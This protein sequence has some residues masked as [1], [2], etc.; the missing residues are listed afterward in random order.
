MSTKQPSGTTRDHI[1]PS[2]PPTASRRH[3]TGLM[4]TAAE[5]TRVKWL[6]WRTRQNRN[7]GQRQVANGHQ[8][9]GRLDALAKQ[10]LVRRQAGGNSKCA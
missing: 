1:S 8:L 4:P 5:N 6:Y 9:L 7:L 2:E 10:P 3:A